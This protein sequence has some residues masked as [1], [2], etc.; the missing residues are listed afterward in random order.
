MVGSHGQV[1]N[2]ISK[3]SKGMRCVPDAAANA[4]GNS[5][6]SI[7]VNGEQMTVGGTSAVAPL[8]AGWKAACDTVAGKI[9]PFSAESV[10]QYV[11]FHDAHLIQWHRNSM[12]APGQSIRA[13]ID[14]AVLLCVL[15][16]DTCHQVTWCG[17]TR[18]TWYHVIPRG[19]T[20]VT[21]DS[22]LVLLGS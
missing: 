7:I 19:I 14:W 11:P 22:A 13:L 4:D 16:R 20:R 10:Y 17:V 3:I 8:L 15:M 2:N 18:V 5:G 1:D 6:Y 12:S 9:L 21:Q